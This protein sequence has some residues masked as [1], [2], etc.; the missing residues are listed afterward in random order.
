MDRW[1][2]T[3]TGYYRGSCL[4]CSA[5]GFWEL[6]FSPVI[7]MSFTIWILNCILARHTQRKVVFFS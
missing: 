4:I 6:P 1:L 7:L 3:G 2:E 5:C